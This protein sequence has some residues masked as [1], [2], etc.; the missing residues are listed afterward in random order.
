[1]DKK[2]QGDT[3]REARLDQ[4]FWEAHWQNR[5]TG[6]D[7]GYPAPA[8]VQYMSQY[9]DKD[10]AILIAGCGN[11]HEA[12]WLLAHGF[13][14]ITLLDIAPKAVERL[15]EKFASAGGVRVLCEDFFEHRGQYD[16]MLEQ[17]FFCA[18]P[19][20]RRPEYV[21]Q[22]AA[23]LRPGGRIVGLLFDRIFENPGP[24]FGGRK[25]AYRALFEPLFRI[26][27]LDA[28]YNSIPPRAGAEVFVNFVSTRRE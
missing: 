20:E 21:A 8:I 6:W 14:R 4:A 28:C 9:A 17:T 26:H 2:E 13:G 12:E 3:V 16:L 24:P 18:I 22:A 27:T 1:M 23:L 11:A 25:D 10:A 15:E 7:I 5:S 19:P